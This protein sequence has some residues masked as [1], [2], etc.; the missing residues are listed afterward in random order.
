MLAAYLTL[1]AVMVVGVMTISSDRDRVVAIILG[2]LSAITM[3]FAPEDD[4]PP[5]HAHIYLAIQTLFVTRLLFLVMNWSVFSILFFVFSAQAMMMLPAKQGY[6]WIAVFTLITGASFL[7][8]EGLLEG[9]LSILTFGGGFLFFGI[10]G[11][12]TKDA[13]NER[14]KSQYLYE[15]LQKTHQELQ[16][17]VLQAEELAVSEE[18]NR[19]A[20]EMHDAIGH[21]LTVSAVQLEGAQRLIPN[22]P[23]KAADMVGTVREQVREALAELR[24]TVATL[25]QPLE[26]GLS[27]SQLLARLV[28][29]FEGATGLNINV[30]VPEDVPA[31]PEFHRTT[32]YRIVQE[33]LTNIQRHAQA[34]QVWLQIDCQD[35]QLSLVVSDN[36]GG[37]PAGAEQNGH[38]L[39][40]IRE[41]AAKLNGEV[42]LEDRTG[43]G[44]QITVNI[45]LPE[46]QLDDR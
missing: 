1:G 45:P 22:E 25:R 29:S 35:K 6:I 9:F 41:R 42:H 39:L 34:E 11:K 32:I 8:I 20:R 13:H 36:G 18:R 31:L 2:I 5:R 40:G 19:L 33:A 46:G 4:A 14:A 12:A 7:R 28:S 17:Y 23:D 37:F 3:Y 16:E 15:E 24:Q 26:A 27:L 30:R 44:G 43:G 21:R 38:G 10:S